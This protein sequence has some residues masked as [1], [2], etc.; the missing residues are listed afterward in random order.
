MNPM[1]NEVSMDLTARLN[2]LARISRAPSPVVSVHLNTRWADEHH[3][4]RVRLFLKNELRRA[5]RATAGGAAAA[6]LD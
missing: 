6:D 5:R 2:E 4:D 3:R 1:P